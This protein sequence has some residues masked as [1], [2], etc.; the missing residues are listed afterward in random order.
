M[1]EIDRPEALRIK[2]LIYWLERAVMFS[3][4]K[5]TI[6]CARADRLQVHTGRVTRHKRWR[7]YSSNRKYSVYGCPS[8]FVFVACV[9]Y[10]CVCARARVGIASPQ[11]FEHL[12]TPSSERVVD[13]IVRFSA[14]LFAFTDFFG[15]VLTRSY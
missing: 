11:Y 3:V 12:K 5:T 7:I 4:V 6:S 14:L 10:M 9:Y 1:G 13:R 2:D 15:A 8:P